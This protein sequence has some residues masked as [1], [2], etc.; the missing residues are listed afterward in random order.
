MQNAKRSLAMIFGVVFLFGMHSASAE[1][2]GK[3]VWNVDYNDQ[4]RQKAPSTT[5]APHAA[6]PRGGYYPSPVY[7]RPAMQR[8]GDASAAW[9][10][11]WGPIQQLTGISSGQASNFM[12]G[13]KTRYVNDSQT[14]LT[15]A[16]DWATIAGASGWLDALTATTSQWFGYVSTDIPAAFS[17]G[18]NSPVFTGPSSAFMGGSAG[19]NSYPLSPEPPGPPS[20]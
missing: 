3:P 16:Q 20:E 18:G 9:G 13:V 12:D 8:Q 10:R 19:Y 2:Q 1:P 17:Q 11:Q 15:N 14:V 6:T 7:R 4:Q 5:P